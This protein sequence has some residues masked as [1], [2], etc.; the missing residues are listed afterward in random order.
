MKGLFGLLLAT[1][2]AGAIAAPATSWVEFSYGEL[3]REWPSAPYDEGEGTDVSLSAAYASSST[4][5]WRLDA[6]RQSHD[7]DLPPLAVGDEPSPGLFVTADTVIAPDASRREFGR[8]IQT[9]TAGI[10][11]PLNS[12]VDL[13]GEIGIARTQVE[14]D[15]VLLDTG[16]PESTELVSISTLT[17]EHEQTGAVGRLG[18]IVEDGSV[19]WGG[20][21][22]WF[23]KMPTGSFE[24]S[25]SVRWWNAYVGY[26][27]TPNW[28]LSLRYADSEELT[29]KG[30][31]LR[32]TL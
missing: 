4:A 25:E 18:I 16:T 8:D 28:T 11:S 17:S 5:Y 2:T 23:N 12:G 27:I 22:E 3:D 29:S 26:R 13:I 9:L 14:F 24:E 7:F 20:T 1:F 10:R 30:V 31:S 6:R 32:W 19:A 15:A 21:M